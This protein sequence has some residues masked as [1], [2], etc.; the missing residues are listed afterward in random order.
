MD[1]ILEYAD[2]YLFT[3]YVYPASWDE[4]NSLRKC[5]SLFLITWSM[6]FIS[7]LL[8]AVPSYFFIFDH[9]MMKHPHFQKNQLRQ[10][11]WQSSYAMPL[12][13]IMS[14]PMYYLEV[15]GRTRLRENYDDACFGYFTAIPELISMIIVVDFLSYTFHRAMH[16]KLVYKYLHKDHHKWK[17]ATPFASHAFHPVDGF[18]QQMP[19]HVCVIIFPVNKYL[20]ITFLVLANIWAVSIHDGEFEMPEWMKSVI[21]GPA[22]HTDHHMYFNYNYGQFFTVWDRLCGSYRHPSTFEGEGPLQYV[23][24]LE[25]SKST[26]TPAPETDVK[27]YETPI[28]SEYDSGVE[29]SGE[30]SEESICSSGSDDGYCEYE[31]A[32]AP[33]DICKNCSNLESSVFELHNSTVNKSNI[34]KNTEKEKTLSEEN[35]FL[36]SYIHRSNNSLE[37]FCSSSVASDALTQRRFSVA[38]EHSSENEFVHKRRRFSFR[39]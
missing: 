34:L 8:V 6:G 32:R 14:T 38:C 21:N 37:L 20:F 10:E 12:M 13:F 36:S 19:Y 2:E 23:H 4:D 28:S 25:S 11:F 33:V 7:Y 35:V 31:A 5:L 22:H 26:S 17:V 30:D 29:S 39:G 1:V 18:L 3:P 27:S 9:D 15:T 24:K 16:H